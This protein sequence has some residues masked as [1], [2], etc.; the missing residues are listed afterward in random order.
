MVASKLTV[1]RTAFCVKTK[2]RV[3][4]RCNDTGRDHR[5]ATTEIRDRFLRQDQNARRGP[6]QRHG[7]TTAVPPAL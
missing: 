6:L 1:Y 3:A 5:G 2:T 7:V 4:A